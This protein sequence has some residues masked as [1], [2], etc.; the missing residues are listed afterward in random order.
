MLKRAELIER[1]PVGVEVNGK[2]IMLVMIDGTPYAINSVCSHRGGPLE[3]G[4]LTDYMVACPWHAA[5]YDV[6]NGNVDPS[7]PWGKHQDSYKVT[8]D[9]N[10]DIWIDA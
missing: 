3:K 5:K 9:A 1:K 6:R 2:K 7:T 10:G 8:I 4:A